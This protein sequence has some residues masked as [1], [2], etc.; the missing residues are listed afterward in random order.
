MPGV[1][2]VS[3]AALYGTPPLRALGENW[4]LLFTSYLPALALATVLYNMTEEIGFT[5]FLFARLQDRHGPLRAALITTVFFWLFH[6]PT[7]V[8]DTGSWALAALVIAIVLLP[9]LAS[10]MILG[11]LYNAAGASVLIAG[12]F[13]ASFNATVNPGGFAVA[14]L[15]LPPGDAFVIL[16]GMVVIVGA[17]VAVATR[18]RLGLP[19]RRGADRSPHA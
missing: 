7:F 17:V 2:L 18:G 8:I 14:V 9:H 4:P 5:G 11:W 3:A 15:D 13:H 10:R 19:A 16:M 1:T 6:L 12:L